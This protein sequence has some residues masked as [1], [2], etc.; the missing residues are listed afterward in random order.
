MRDVAVSKMEGNSFLFRIPNPSTRNC[1]LNQRL[2]QIKGQTMFV[3]KWDLGVAPVKPELTS[4][5]I[6]LELRNV[7][8]QFFNEEGLE[9]IAG[10]V[11]EPKD[12]HPATANKT[13]LEVAKVFTII[14]PRKPL[15]EAVNVQFESGEIKRIH[16]SSPWM[17]P[18]CSHCKE[19]GHSLGHCKKAPITCK[20]CR[21]TT[22]SAEQCPR[23]KHAGS[24]QT[25]NH[26]RKR[27]KI[28]KGVG[29]DTGHWAVKGFLP[30]A[31]KGNSSP[32]TLTSTLSDAE[33]AL[34]DPKNLL[35]G[36]SS[37]TRQSQ[38]ASESSLVA[39]ETHQNSDDYSE[40]DTDSD[41]ER[42]SSDIM[43]SNSEEE[44]ILKKLDKKQLKGLRG[45]SLKTSV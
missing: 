30:S 35:D 12:L 44:A 26:R 16:V 13:I 20:T 3:A 6:W 25:K 17:P 31:Q 14:D 40:P 4:A 10:F 7:P 2:W 8:F 23:A 1:V 45:K 19:I 29:S 27:S 42:D 39:E 36:E 18:V 21:V 5:L 11:G 22:H 9:H 37:G 32:T 34:G 38:K 24:R 33:I 41:P 28:P 43:S 15:P